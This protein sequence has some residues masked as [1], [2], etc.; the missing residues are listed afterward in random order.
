MVTFD[1]IESLAITFKLMQL[2]LLDVNR[3]HKSNITILLSR[4]V[5]SHKSEEINTL[6]A[7]SSDNF[8][9]FVHK[10]PTNFHISQYVVKIGMR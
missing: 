8:M 2:V 10:V 4:N 5:Y 6:Q 9:R 1:S 7:E 3:L